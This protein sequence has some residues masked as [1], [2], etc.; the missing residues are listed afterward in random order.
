MEKFLWGKDALDIMNLAPEV[1]RTMDQ[2]ITWLK[3]LQHRAYSISSSP[4]AHAGEVH[5]TVAAVRWTYKDRAHRGVCSTFLADLAPVGA[6][7]GIFMM[8]NK[9]FRVPENNDVPMVMVGPGTGIA[10]FR[11]FLE[12]RQARGAQG[13]NWLFFGDQHRACDFIYEDQISR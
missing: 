2:L 4:K 12:E 11:A 8:P 13:T 5:L 7:A 9:T 6:E 3:P 1:K 10:P